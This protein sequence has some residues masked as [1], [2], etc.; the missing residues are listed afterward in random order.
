M[1]LNYSSDGKK[2]TLKLA[3]DYVNYSDDVQKEA[4]F[5]KAD[6]K[7]LKE[8]VLDA[9]SLGKW[10]STLVVVLFELIQ[11]AQARKIAVQQETLPEGMR[12]LLTLAFTVG[13]ASGVDGQVKAGYL[14]QIGAWGIDSYKSAHKGIRFLW[15][16]LKSIKRFVF[17]KAIMRPVDFWFALQECGPKA[18]LIVSLISFMVGLIL[19]FVGAIQL[20]LFG[21]QIYV[22]SLVTV[23]MTRIMG[24]IMMGIIMAGRTGSAYAATI[25]TMQV[26]E[27]LD[28]LKTF[29]IPASDFLVLPRVVALVIAMPFLTILADFM[30]MFGGAAV[31]IM[32]LDI[33]PHEYWKYSVDAFTLN[34]FL[35][36]IFHGFVFGYIIAL[37]GCYYGIYCGRDAN[38]VGLATTRA[39]VSSIVWMILMTGVI[40]WAFEVM[41][42]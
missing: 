27:E 12:R 11:K 16:S 26:N 22:A 37:C 40:T 13:R 29:A 17:Q 35:V 14:E 1:D 31:S 39:V 32:M 36:G 19:A 34:N 41:G 8:I 4:L 30:G 7:D 3:G 42:I 24:A 25:G 10:D 33:S 2:L 9:A 5:S 20:K 15:E 38:S 6:R 18:V 21:A 28:A 23:G